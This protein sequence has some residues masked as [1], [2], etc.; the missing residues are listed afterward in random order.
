MSTRGILLALGLAAVTSP[1]A[2]WAAA[3]LRV[4]EAIP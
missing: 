3:A 2:V 1:A 4:I